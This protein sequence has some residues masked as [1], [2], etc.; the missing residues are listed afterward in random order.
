ML[1]RKIALIILSLSLM[2]LLGTSIGWAEEEF[3]PIFTFHTDLNL[4][5][6]SY[7]GSFPDDPILEMPAGVVDPEEIKYW[8]GQIKE[9]QEV[10]KRF[11]LTNPTIPNISQKVAL[12]FYAA[13]S[14]DLEMIVKLNHQGM[15]GGDGTNNSLSFPLILNEAYLNY[16]TN[17]GMITAGKFSY[18]L[19][20]MGLIIGDN[21]TPREGVMVYSKYKNFWY[22]VVYNRLLMSLYRDY[23]YVSTYLWDD[24]VAFRTS[25]YIKDQFVGL[26]LLATGFYDEKALT[27]DYNG[28]I[29]GHTAKAEV[30]LVYPL[31]LHRQRVGDRVWPGGVAS[32]NWIE[33][34]DNFL[35]FKVGALSKGFIPNYG[36][37]SNMDGSVKFSPNTAGIEILYQ[38]GLTADLLLGVDLVASNILDQ[39][40][41]EQMQRRDT[42]RKLE[43][44]LTKYLNQYT[45]LSLTTAY[46]GDDTFD[47]GKINL[48]W[49]IDY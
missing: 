30:G 25:T 5:V 42:L 44:K 10:R 33:D 24:L 28:K 2:L 6:D 22:S 39:T 15:W 21:L 4:V 43:F 32:I 36:S 46:L 31:W 18:E 1:Q 34:Q 7:F 8:E 26:N 48:N 23:P 29:F 3:Q 38:R 17:W 14:P 47:Y 16:L 41:Q 40:Y 37:R 20:T 11:K 27:I 9:D 12:Q 45:N 13:P 49:Q 35:Q 19:D